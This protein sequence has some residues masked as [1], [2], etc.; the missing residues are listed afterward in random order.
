ME[1]A[2]DGVCSSDTI[3]YLTCRCDSRSEAGDVPCFIAPTE[4]DG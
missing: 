1:S 3:E 4:V 2:D